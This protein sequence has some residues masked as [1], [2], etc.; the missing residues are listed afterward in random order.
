MLFNNITFRQ[1]F[2]NFKQDSTF[3]AYY[4]PSFETALTLQT[5]AA[6]AVKQVHL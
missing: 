4:F 2:L 1:R 5:Q 3:N 6:K